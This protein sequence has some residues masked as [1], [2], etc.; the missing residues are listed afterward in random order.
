MRGTRAAAALAALAV[1]V[2]GCSDD[3]PTPRVEPSVSPS[4]STTP[5]SPSGEPSDP[6]TPRGPE[7]TVRAWVEA[8]NH[9]VRTGDPSAVDALSSSDC[10]TCEDSTSPVEQIYLDGG[11]FETF[12]WRVSAI[13]VLSSD[14]HS[15]QVGA[16]VV[17]AA[18]RT[19]PSPGAEPVAYEVERHIAKFRLTKEAGTWKLR[20]LVYLS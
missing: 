3:E 17:Y 11:H 7:E 13:K 15:A 6:P 18:G 10:A 19:I 8:R 14:E 4:P 20:Q 5:A 12:G 9:L 1:L 16:A 2:S